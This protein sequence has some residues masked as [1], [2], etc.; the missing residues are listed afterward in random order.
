MIR[1]S[2]AM[3][4]ILQVEFFHYKK[5]IEVYRERKDFFAAFV[6]LD[7][8]YDRVKIKEMWKRLE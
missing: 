7:K 5:N 6:N 3:K 2:E 8:V 1:C 4:G